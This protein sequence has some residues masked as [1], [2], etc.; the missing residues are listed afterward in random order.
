MSIHFYWENYLDQLIIICPL[1]RTLQRIILIDLASVLFW[2]TFS[3]ILCIHHIRRLML[4]CEN[5]S[6]SSVVYFFNIAC[7]S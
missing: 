4:N 5:L 2:I 6:N 1:I 3:N 7:L